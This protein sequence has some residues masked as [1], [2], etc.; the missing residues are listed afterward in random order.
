MDYKKI[1]PSKKLRLKL[2]EATNFI[3]DEIMI[4]FQYKIKTGVD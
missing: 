4:K 3:P 2:L 1:I